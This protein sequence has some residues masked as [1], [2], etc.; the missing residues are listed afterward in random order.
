LLAGTSKV[1]RRGGV[2]EGTM[3]T[4]KPDDESTGAGLKVFDYFELTGFE[5]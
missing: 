1:R 4:E 2:G 5:T 3:F